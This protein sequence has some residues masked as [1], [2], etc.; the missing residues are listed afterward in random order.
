L[1]TA[2][3]ATQNGSFTTPN[4]AFIQHDGFYRGPLLECQT[5]KIGACGTVMRIAFDSMFSFYHCVKRYVL[6]A[7]WFYTGTPSFDYSW[8]MSSLGFEMV[9]TSGRG[10]TWAAW[11]R[12]TQGGTIIARAGAGR[13]WQPGGK[14]MFVENG[15]LRFDVGWVGRRSRIR[16]W[17]TAPGITWR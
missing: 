13:E 5:K 4:E 16:R 17:P 15:R 7:K 2:W 11:I 14:V 1:Q 10:F 3:T 8:I 12:T 9:R 6:D